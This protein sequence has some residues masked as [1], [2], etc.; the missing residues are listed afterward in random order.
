MKDN[1]LPSSNSVL[2]RLAIIGAVAVGFIVYAYGWTETDINLRVTQ[3]ETR[4]ANVQRAFCELLSPNVLSQDTTSIYV[5]V[6]FKNQCDGS[7]IEQPTRADGEPYAEFSAYCGQRNDVVTVEGFNFPPHSAGRVAW[8][9]PSGERQP[10]ELT[11][12]ANACGGAAVFDI[13]ANGY[14]IVDVRVPSIRGGAEDIQTVD[15]EARSLVGNPYV[16]TS[17]SLVIEKMIETIFLALMA[18]TLALPISI[19]LSFLAAHNLMKPIRLPLGNVLI[20]FILLVVGWFLGAAIL[21]PIGQI[22]VEWGKEPLKGIIVP[23]AGMVAY[24]VGSQAAGKFK[25]DNPLARLRR[26]AMSLLLL[27]IIV[28]TLGAL[29][30]IFVWLGGQLTTGLGLYIGNFLGTIGSL[31]ELTIVLWAAFFSAFTVSSIGSDLTA[32]LVKV[33]DGV[34]GRVL[35]GIL[36]AVS[37]FLLMAGVAAFSS[38][39]ALFT[40]VPP[41]FAAMLG[42]PLVGVLYDWQFGKSPAQRTLTDRTTRTLLSIVASVVIFVLTTHILDVMRYVVS[43][44]LPLGEFT[45]TSAIIGAI[46][47]GLGGLAMGMQAAF[48]LGDAIYNVTRTLLNALRSIEPLIMGLVF[49]IWVGIGPFAGV[50]ALTLHSIASLG[51]L[52]SEQIESIDSGP[53][54]AIQSTGATRLQTIIY[55]VV[56]QIVPPYIAFT[57]YRWDINVRMSTIIGFVGGGGIGFLLNQQINLLQYREAGVAV[58]AIA[59]VVSILDYASASIRE[60]LI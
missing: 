20:S 9:R 38:Q 49:V 51:K 48:P 13:D 52:F 60:R 35:G 55:A 42:G 59:V 14:F 27:V 16:S 37:G 3:E 57:M 4:Q 19:F 29:G 44:R 6:N 7:T 54:E 34:E 18:T 56:P 26:I 1:N 45:T 8:V 36:G 5:P 53:I 10:F 30:G 25:L 58:L 11:Q 24:G 15:I 40:V 12:P 28:F 2:R 21:G 22:A 46:L 17:A 31:I 47:G 39:A 43:G 41:V 50:L 23:A 33:I 32:N